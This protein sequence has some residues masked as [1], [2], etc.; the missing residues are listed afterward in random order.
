MYKPL[1]K[2]VLE[3]GLILLAIAMF[4]TLPAQDYE[5]TPAPFN[6]R[7]ADFSATFNGENILLCSARSRKSLSFSDDSITNYYTDLYSC[8]YLG[9]GLY[10]APQPI[11]G[12]VNSKYN[13]GH[14]CFNAAG[15]RMYYTANLDRSLT[16]KFESVDEFKLGVFTADL[17]NGKWVKS[18]EFI[19]N[20]KNGKYS[21]AH[22]C[23]SPNDSVLYFSSN[24][25]GGYGGSDIYRC[26]WKDSVWSQPQNL[27]N[28]VNGK[29]NEFYPFINEAGVLFLSTD[30][31]NDSEGMDIYYSTTADGFFQKPLRL[32]NS[33]NSEFDD[34][35]YQEQHGLSQGCF[36]S[37]R[38]GGQDDVFLFSKYI[39]SFS[40]CRENYLSPWCYKL[41]DDSP[42][43]LQDSPLVYEWVMGDGTIIHGN[44]V[45]YCYG[46]LGKYHVLLR[47]VD[48]LNHRVVHTIGEY[49]FVIGKP[50][51]PYINSRDTLMTSI[52]FQC[53]LQIEDFD[54]FTVDKIKWE[55]DDGTHYTGDSFVH[56]FKDSGPH[57]VK[58]DITGKRNGSSSFPH[59]CVFKDIVCI[60]ADVA[61]GEIAM[62]ECP[63]D[64]RQYVIRMDHTTFPKGIESRQLTPVYKL[65]FA[66][67]KQSLSF[68]HEVFSG[69][70]GEISEI[71]TDSSYQYVL[72]ET[73]SWEAILPLYAR[74]KA[75]GFT[76]LYI[77]DYSEFDLKQRTLR[78]GTASEASIPIEVSE[79]LLYRIVLD[80]SSIRIPLTDSI[81]H[82]VR[83]EIA[84]LRTATG[85]KYTIMTEEDQQRL[86]ATMDK[87]KSYGFSGA[88]IEQFTLRHMSEH[89][90]KTGHYIRPGDT[91]K[92]NK[93]FSRLT[94]I[95]FEFNKAELQAESRPTLDYIASMLASMEDYTLN[96]SAHTCNIGTAKS[97]QKLSEDRASAVVKYLIAKGVPGQNLIARGFGQSDPI[98]PNTT[99]EGRAANRRVEFVIEFGEKARRA[100]N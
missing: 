18:G 31:R 92:L 7:E 76:D 71:R 93:E 24:M 55:L 9:N 53:K 65:V 43:S 26:I 61:N 19:H 62:Q 64:K 2:K 35:A 15:T 69:V 68:A 49:D 52:P 38:N 21:V 23:I 88:Y 41:S 11:E 34:F 80:S 63:E 54:D 37:N 89:L 47:V 56:I 4:H 95:R 87:T 51:R 84:E 73:C 28:K 32:N 6:S 58:C 8:K 66:E 14:T 97:N 29:G 67:S 79:Q 91:Y 70:A 78:T 94:D 12:N 75:Q 72:S 27:G 48:T 3:S 81:F 59:T 13:E 10:G 86:Q 1:K 22:P 57:Q 40:D 96:I 77:A 82:L 46:D 45:D 25:P 44:A 99:E 42:L 16:N 33:I 83:E 100:M 5:I 20:S 90:V 74:L 85:Y 36:S 98:R 17:I 39:T 60:P 30:G 50:D